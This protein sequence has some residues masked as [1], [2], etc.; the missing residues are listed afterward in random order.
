MM[1]AGEAELGFIEIRGAL[2]G[3]RSR[4]IGRD[5]LI[6]VVPPDHKWIRRSAGSA[7]QNSPNPFG[8]AQIGVAAL[9]RRQR[10]RTRC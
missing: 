2:H 3:L 6:V 9:A 7:L 8:I 1:R 5:E 4:V 10:G